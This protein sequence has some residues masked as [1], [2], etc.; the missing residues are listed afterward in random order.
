VDVVQ[1]A[2]ADGIRPEVVEASS[3]VAMK[4]DVRISKRYLI[5]AG[6]AESLLKAGCGYKPAARAALSRRERER[7]SGSVG[8]GWGSRRIE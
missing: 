2:V 5:E 7:A 1:A 8:G 4:T 3:K 6:P